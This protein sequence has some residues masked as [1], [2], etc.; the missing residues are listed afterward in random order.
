MNNEITRAIA[1]VYWHVGT[2]DGYEKNAKE[3]KVVGWNS[4]DKSDQVERSMKDIAGCPNRSNIWLKL[5]YK[6]D[7]S[8]FSDTLNF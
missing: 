3:F 4:E 5:E 7:D 6:L 2:E 1:S 8:N